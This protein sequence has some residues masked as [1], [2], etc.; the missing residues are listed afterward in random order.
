[1]INIAN[2]MNS[3]LIIALPLIIVALAGVFS[4]RSGIVNIALEGIM[5]VG[6]TTGFII[7]YFMKDWSFPNS[8]F[9]AAQLC[10][11]IAII[12]AA[13]ISSLYASLLSF[14]AIKLKANQII[15]GTAL[16]ILPPAIGFCICFS[17]IIVNGTPTTTINLANWV[18]ITPDALGIVRTDANAWVIDLFLNHMFLTVPVI[19]ILI[20]VMSLVLYKTKFGL[21]LRSCGENPY[22]AD[23]VGI[24]VAKMRYIGVA[25]AGALAG[26]GGLQ[27]AFFSGA[28]FSPEFGVSGAGFLALAL[29]IFGNWKPSRIVI[30]SILFSFFI[31]FASQQALL[32]EWFPLLKS[33]S[34]ISYILKMTPYLLTLIILII[35]SK[36]SRAPKAEG[37]P[38]D[39]EVRV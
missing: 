10:V 36:T 15:I 38:Y 33:I 21:R 8:N 2:G 14:A 4:E 1:M 35:T 31:F 37:I 30:V 13:L 25:I 24:D 27:Y 23:S 20:I 16:N 17:L 26:I 9:F 39:K 6:A 29:M 34:G 12:L 28:S 7:V 3:I 5:V 22:A 32:I 19:I 18:N 11:L